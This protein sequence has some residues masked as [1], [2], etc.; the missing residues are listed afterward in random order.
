MYG[1][2]AEIFDVPIAINPFMFWSPPGTSGE[3]LYIKSVATDHILM[4][5]KLNEEVLSQ[6]ITDKRAVHTVRISDPATGRFRD[7]VG[8]APMSIRKKDGTKREDGENAIMKSHTKA[9]RRGVLSFIGFTMLEESELETMGETET[10]SKGDQVADQAEDFA[11]AYAEG[12]TKTDQVR[13]EAARRIGDPLPNT[14]ADDRK[15][16]AQ[17]QTQGWVDR[18]KKREAAAD[19]S[20]LDSHIASLPGEADP[21]PSLADQAARAAA[22]PEPAKPTGKFAEARATVTEEARQTDELIEHIKVEMNEVAPKFEDA[23]ATL[24]AKLFK[25]MTEYADTVHGFSN[26][27]QGRIRDGVIAHMNSLIER[28]N[29]KLPF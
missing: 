15:H 3:I 25:K 1:Q 21:G 6:T 23:P 27:A 14:Y 4:K 17:E 5:Q 28:A 8:A 13:A 24:K 16:A 19:Q 2:M 22:P 7:S 11:K 26:E 9:V 10:Q 12:Q 29:K 18:E 20:D